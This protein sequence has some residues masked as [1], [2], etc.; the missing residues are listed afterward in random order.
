MPDLLHNHEALEVALITMVEH[1]AKAAPQEGALLAG[2]A[3]GGIA[4]AQRL[5]ELWQSSARSSIEV[6]S[7]NSTF[8]RDDIGAHPFALSKGV[9]HLPGGITGRTVIII[10]DVFHTGRTA[11]AALEELMSQGRPRRV[12]LAVLAERP[13]R[14]L[15]I[16]PDIVG[17]HIN[18]PEDKRVSVRLNAQG[19]NAEDAI[20]C[21]AFTE[22]GTPD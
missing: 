20:H 6:G 10:D 19:P 14:L 13:G 3:H 12:L 18:V 16:R 15:P 7:L 5:G 9:T 17:L 4:V 11:R 2:V 21:G 22:P 1:M 8:H